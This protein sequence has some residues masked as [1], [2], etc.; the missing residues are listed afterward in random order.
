MLAERGVF[1]GG[2]LIILGLAL[3]DIVSRCPCP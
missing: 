2:L 1:W 3:A